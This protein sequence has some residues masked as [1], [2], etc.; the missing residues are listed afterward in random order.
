MSI[1]EEGGGESIPP[2]G[3]IRKSATDASNLLGMG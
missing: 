3:C 2:E 1:D